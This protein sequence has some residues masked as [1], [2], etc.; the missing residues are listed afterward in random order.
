ML[1]L[2]ILTFVGVVKPVVPNSTRKDPKMATTKAIRLRETIIV[3][4]PSLCE[5]NYDVA[6]PTKDYFYNN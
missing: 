1:L 6:L 2:L 4:V 3:L 5:K